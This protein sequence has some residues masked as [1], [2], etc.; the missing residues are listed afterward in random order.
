MGKRN[1]KDEAKETD[2]D[3]RQTWHNR[4]E[5]TTRIL[6]HLSTVAIDR[7]VICGGQSV[8]VAKESNVSTNTTPKS[9][10]LSYRDIAISVFTDPDEPEA[11][12][13]HCLRY[14]EY[15]GKKVNN[16]VDR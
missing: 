16:H 3:S 11:I 6:Q 2:P 14:P 10:T 13:K 4:P 7:H 12:R 9:K 15:W 8:A 5:R 1:D